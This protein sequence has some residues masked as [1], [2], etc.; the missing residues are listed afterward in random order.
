MMMHQRT[1]RA[2]VIHGPPR[3]SQP[4]AR[5][6]APCAPDLARHIQTDILFFGTQI[7]TL[8]GECP[9]GCPLVS[10][11][12]PT[13]RRVPALSGTA[14]PRSKRLEADEQYIRLDMAR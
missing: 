3:R 8:A 5:G 7:R 10:P 12:C 9:R 2:I 13:R 1:M 4:P 14:G 6:R 11:E